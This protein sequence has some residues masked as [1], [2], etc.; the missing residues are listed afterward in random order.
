[1]S[2]VYAVMR[3]NAV[4]EN[5]LSSRKEAAEYLSH[6]ET[7]FGEKH[8]FSIEEAV[9]ETITPFLQRV[10]LNDNG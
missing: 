8:T 7:I 1:M 5:T 4:V 10:V 9:V 2:V 6:C 3:D